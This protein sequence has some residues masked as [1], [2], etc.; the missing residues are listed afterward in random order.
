MLTAVYDLRA[1]GHGIIVLIIKLHYH[2]HRRGRA[3]KK[4]CSWRP[5]RRP[6][7][8]PAG[9]RSSGRGGE[10]GACEG[11]VPED[12]YFVA[13][14]CVLGLVIMGRLDVSRPACF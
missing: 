7:P 8:A 13:P 2:W 14:A 6:P 10:A 3:D 5:W 4:G 9:E 12:E 11:F 1:K